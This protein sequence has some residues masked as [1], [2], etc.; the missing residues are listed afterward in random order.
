MP[1]SIFLNFIHK[2][3]PD[4]GVPIS[5]THVAG[6]F[7]GFIFSWTI[8]EFY[9]ADILVTTLAIIY[10]AWMS[11]KAESKK[12]FPTQW[13][14]YWIIFAFIYLFEFFQFIVYYIP[15]FQ[16]AKLLLFLWCMYPSTNNGAEVIYGNVLKPALAALDKWVSSQLPTVEFPKDDWIWKQI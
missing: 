9:C 6:A 5:P 8:T 3:I 1:Y 4:V 12:S 2:S 11:Y 10:P 14:S 16:T 7:W 13:M 15:C